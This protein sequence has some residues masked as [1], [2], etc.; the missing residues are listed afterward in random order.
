MINRLKVLPFQF[1]N[2]L[3]T[4]SAL[5]V[6]SGVNIYLVGGVVRDLILKRAVFD[7][8][9][10]VEGDAI[11]FAH[12]LS[13]KIKGGFKKHHAFGTATVCFNKHKIDF[14]TA[15]TEIYSHQGALP[16]VK[17]A[18]L[19]EDLIRRDF[20]INAMA[21][22]LNKDSYGQLI[23]IYSGL[24]DLKDKSIRILHDGSFLDDPTR[25]LRAIRF[26][27]RFGFRIEKHTFD[28]MKQA[29]DIDA[30]SL[31]NPHRLRDELILILQESKPAVYIKRVND[32]EGFNFVDSE[33][34]LKNSA[35]KL[36]LRI[37]KCVTEYKRKHKKHRDL[38]VWILYL[39]AILIE[40]STQKIDK[41]L[42]DFGF[43]KGERIIIHSIKEGVDKIKKLDKNLKKHLVYE[44][45][46]PYSYES[47][48]FFCAYYHNR[49]KLIANIE[50]FW[51][52][53]VDTHLRI[54][55]RDLKKLDLRPLD[56]Y[57]RV[58]KELLYIKIDKG[59]K[60]KK[61]EIAEAR[62]IFK[63]ISS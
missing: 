17:P 53:L 32:L 40:L 1:R 3:K 28:L 41:I 21:I 6:S 62:K 34:K 50:C 37:Q 44:Y 58:L 8:D 51:S 12:K 57:N 27:Q 20:T 36:F 55:G 31:V 2:F 16:K 29:I 54:K 4:A 60:G 38:E 19:V 47:I 18:S 63:K 7:L 39:A 56:S 48:L 9:I 10:V 46:N 49:S 11:S 61:E 59:L 15:R 13:D 14:T 43:K 22:S 5:A 25:I 33:I 24:K 30:L 52:D 26:E 35:F 23:D 45:L 42:S